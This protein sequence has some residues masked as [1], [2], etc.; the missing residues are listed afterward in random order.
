MAIRTVPLLMWEELQDA[1][2]LRGERARLAAALRRCPPYARRRVRLEMRLAEVTARL[3]A[4]ELELSR[5]QILR[6]E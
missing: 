5:D 1:D 3:L 4:T 2:A 6:R